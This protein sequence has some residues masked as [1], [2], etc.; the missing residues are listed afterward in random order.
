MKQQTHRANALTWQGPNIAWGPGEPALGCWDRPGDP[1]WAGYHWEGVNLAWNPEPGR[2]LRA[3]MAAVLA[4][5][6]RCVSRG[7]AAQPAPNR[8][9][10]TL[11]R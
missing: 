10:P 6:I 3:E 8:R 9:L 11:G 7:P 2:P 4:H 5:G 1:G